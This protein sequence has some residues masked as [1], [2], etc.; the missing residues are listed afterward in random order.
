VPTS[1]VDLRQ[2]IGLAYEAAE[3][4]ASW[5]GFLERYGK[6][7][8][9]DKTF[10]Q[11][12]HFEARFSHLVHSWGVDV[13]F[14]TSYHDHYSKVNVWRNIGRSKYVQGR[15]LLDEELYPRPLL[16]K[17]EF[18]NDYLLP[19]GGVFS[20]GAVIAREPGR[21]M[22]LTALRGHANHQW[23][24]SESE[25]VEILLPHLGRAWAIH[26]RLQLLD[27][28]ERVLDTV[29][30][31]IV[32]LTGAGEI[33]RCN[34]LAEQM[35]EAGDGLSVRHARL[36]AIDTSAD[37]QLRQAIRAAASPRPALACPEAVSVPRSSMQRAYQVMTA[38][39]HN[40]PSVFAGMRS[41]AVV[42]LVVDPDRQRPA[43]TGLL[44]R[45]FGLTP[46]E[47]DLASALS[48]GGSLE[49]AAGDLGMTYETARSHLRRIFEK[50]VTSRQTELILLLGRLPKAP[51]LDGL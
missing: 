7:V 34:R 14:K 50:T 42:A 2:L 48:A 8:G 9:A 36:H 20:L 45:M 32:F 44:I 40:R 33:I 43:A 49:Q 27:A 5:P 12:H 35:L 23:N 51:T 4:P 39:L 47:A 31:G 26:E 41:P 30:V 21:A 24:R 6:V 10:I 29:D 17:S 13:S 1:E 37:A 46:R 19:A 3:N 18:Y 22:M 16:V 38:P 25:A 11:F 28:A 15:A